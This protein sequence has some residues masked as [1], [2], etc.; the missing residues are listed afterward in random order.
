MMLHRRRID[1][2]DHKTFRAHGGALDL[3]A[4]TAGN[5]D[6]DPTRRGGRRHVDATVGQRDPLPIE[7]GGQKLLARTGC[8]SAGGSLA[9][10]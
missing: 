1:M 7:I 6:I 8:W 3:L 4:G 2:I 9:R 10:R 5:R